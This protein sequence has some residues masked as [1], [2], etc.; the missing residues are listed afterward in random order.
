MILRVAERMRISKFILYKSFI[1]HCYSLVVIRALFHSAKIKWCPAPFLVAW[2][3]AGKD[4]DA[5][6]VITSALAS[7]KEPLDPLAKQGLMG[8]LTVQACILCDKQQYGEALPLL[9]QS[10]D[11]AKQ[12]KLECAYMVAGWYLS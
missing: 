3:P 12:L 8:L 9:Q 11:I 6:Q 5:E 4:D 10:Y 2:M 1:M 7:V